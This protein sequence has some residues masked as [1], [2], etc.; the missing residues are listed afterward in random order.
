MRLFHYTDVH[1]VHSILT[2]QK[3]W[4]T[5]MR[6]LNDT[7]EFQHGFKRLLSAIDTH[8]L[9]VFYNHND[10]FV[11]RAK[12]TIL[13]IFKDR[14]NFTGRSMDPVYICSLSANGD[15][16][17]QWRAYG[18]YAIE[19][20]EQ[21]LLEENCHI[22]KCIYDPRK[23]AEI[24]KDAII[25]TITL[26]SNKPDPGLV[27]DDGYRQ[28]DKLWK[29]ASSFKDVGFRE[30]A[31]Y[32]IIMDGVDENSV[33]YRP[34]GNLLVP[35]VELEIPMNCIKA[36]HLGPMLNYELASESMVGLCRQIEGTWRDNGG[37]IED[38]IEVKT[39]K[40][41]FRTF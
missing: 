21:I 23:Q 12:Q 29:I 2:K 32:R 20:D 36:I 13:Q 7:E 18:T 14:G 11:E 39:S 1:A 8:E 27:D 10:G 6:Y 15:S 24:A 4:L 41:P 40:I 30:E 17:S 37:S 16:L 31:E 3:L 38:Y 33:K 34:R 22:A 26:L 35:Y 25:D 19:F 9:S 28:F 5:D